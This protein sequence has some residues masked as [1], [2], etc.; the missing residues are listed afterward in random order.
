MD[1]AY[2]AE[3]D[4][5]FVR[6]VSLIAALEGACKTAADFLVLP[7]LGMARS[8]LTDWG[9]H[10]PTHFEDPAIDSFDAALDQL[11]CLLARM[12]TETQDL[13][14]TLRLRVAHELLREAISAH[15]NEPDRAIVHGDVIRSATPRPPPSN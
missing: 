7:Y 6:A 2:D 9:L 15:L 13:A 3:S 12:R 1:G 10:L 5:D 8:E 14:A 4:P 11:D